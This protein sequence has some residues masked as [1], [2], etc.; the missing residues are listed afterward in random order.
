MKFGMLLLALICF[1]TFRTFATDI[2]VGETRNWTVREELVDEALSFLGTPYVSAGVS[3]DGVDCSGLVYRVYKNVVGEP[4]PRRVSDLIKVGN[5]VE[6]DPKPGDLHFFDTTGGPSHV[7]ISIGGREFVHAASEGKKTGVIVSSLDKPYYKTRYLGSR[8]LVDNE[9]AIITINVDDK[10][11]RKVLSGTVL[12][13]EPVG[14]AINSAFV[15]PVS[16][17]FNVF[18]GERFV[19]AKRLKIRNQAE[20]P[21]L[22]WFIPAAGDWTV[23]LEDAS[24]R[25]L[26]ALA[27]TSGGS[28]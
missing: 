24:G 19:F 26:A 5:G 3:R 9:L 18:Y 7:G 28:R 15:Q 2:K 1:F 16:F 11:A 10:E 22:V 20:S 13:G 4:L 25:N 27:F 8:Q 21:S 14:F 17:V 12:A 6:G 23:S